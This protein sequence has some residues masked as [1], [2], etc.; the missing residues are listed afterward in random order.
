MQNIID[1]LSSMEADE[2]KIEDNYEKYRDYVVT[3]KYVPDINNQNN[4]ICLANVIQNIF[5]TI[6]MSLPNADYIK[7]YCRNNINVLISFNY[8]EVQFDFSLNKTNEISFRSY[9]LPL[10][11]HRRGHKLL[12]K[13][14]NSINSQNFKEIGYFIRP[15][16][17]YI[18]YRNEL[19][20]NT[21]KD[22][23]KGLFY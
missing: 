22:L 14:V 19:W 20:I 13:E 16:I 5:K 12:T 10:K 6:Q 18:Y 23:I 21:K 8:K 11:K 15:I 17:E 9:S 1:V 2:K 7:I 3:Q 4:L